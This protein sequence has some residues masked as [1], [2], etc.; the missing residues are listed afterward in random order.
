MTFG[1]HAHIHDVHQW[2]QA[3]QA[4]ASVV[5]G[6]EKQ[7]SR[8]CCILHHF[9]PLPSDG[10]LSSPPPH[11]AFTLLKASS[12][13]STIER[14]SWKTNIGRIDGGSDDLPFIFF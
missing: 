13:S 8:G 11:Q 9:S 4:S 5:S 7:S 10:L 2:A 3:A 1:A 14:C 6:D 12:D